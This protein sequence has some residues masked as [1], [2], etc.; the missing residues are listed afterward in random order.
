[1]FGVCL[2]LPLKAYESTSKS[3]ALFKHQIRSISPQAS[4][5]GKM[6]R[7]R[8]ARIMQYALL[9]FGVVLGAMGYLT[10]GRCCTSSFRA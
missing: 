4:L 8:S 2:F 6:N 3:S 1:M 10:T 9:D 5:I 7:Y